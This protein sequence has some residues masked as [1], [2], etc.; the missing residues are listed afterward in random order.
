MSDSF[1]LV[2]LGGGCAG[3]SLSMALAARGGLCPRT[4]V[5]EPRTTYTNDRTWCYWND[6]SV[7]VPYPVQHRWQTMRVAH[8]GQRVLLG[9][10]STPYHMLAAQDFYAAAH[11]LID[12]Q[13]NITLRQGVSVLGE[14]SRSAG[15]WNVRTSSG[16]VMARSI[17]DTRPPMLPSCDGATLWQSLDRKSV[18]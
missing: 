9:C 7:A 10:G 12:S 13:Q 1:D 11:A 3:L 18:V 8:A 15:M 16:T 5:I 6:A 2:V 4:L 17:V 14:P